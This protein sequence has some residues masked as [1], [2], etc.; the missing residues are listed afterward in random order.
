LKILVVLLV[1]VIFLQALMMRMGVFEPDSSVT[2]RVMNSSRNDCVLRSIEIETDEA[3]VIVDKQRMK[4]S[5]I[6]SRR[7]AFVTVYVDKKEKLKYRV[8]ANFEACASIESPSREVDPG[9]LIYEWV[10]DK[11]IKFQVRGSN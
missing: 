7:E 8:K 11:E 9:W 1:L 4:K 10:K 5:G 3:T 6:T 2:F